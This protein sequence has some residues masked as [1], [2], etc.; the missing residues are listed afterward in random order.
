MTTA[1]KNHPGMWLADGPAKAINDLED[2]YGPIIINRA[3]VTEAEQQEVIDQWDRGDR[4]G[5]YPP[6]RPAYTSN[7]VKNGGQAVDVYNFTD[8]RAKLNEFG[9][10]WYGTS[11]PVHYTYVGRPADN[12]NSGL[13]TQWIKIVQE[14]LIRMGHDLGPWGADG[15]LG[16]KTKAAVRHEQSMAGPNGNPGGAL[17]QDG[18]PGPLTNA[19]LDWWLVGRFQNAGG[20]PSNK[21]ASELT[22]ADIQ[23]ALNR[24]GYGLR[25]DNEWGPKSRAAL[26]DFQSRNGLKADGWVGPNTWDKLNT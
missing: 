21:S 25:V 11:D 1:L 12:A 18:I 6:A 7:H 24:K 22:Y 16:D 13:S 20:R 3:G 17:V 19:Y 4:A 26:L 5:L 9:F 23:E 2:K 8:D 14:K 10:E 15:V